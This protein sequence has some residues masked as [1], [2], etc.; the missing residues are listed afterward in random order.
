MNI[1]L[2]VICGA[3]TLSFLITIITG[4]ASIKADLIFPSPR[5]GASVSKLTSKGDNGFLN[6]QEYLNEISKRNIFLSIEMKNAL[7]QELTPDF[8]QLVQDLK[9]VG[10]IWS[11]NPEVMIESTK[12]KRTYLLKKGDTF[13]KFKIKDITR[14]SAILEMDIEGK[15]KEYELR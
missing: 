3:S 2:F 10:V 1:G 14:S 7:G 12:E 5:V 8:T 6:I 15:P 13:S 11:S 4:P 9:L